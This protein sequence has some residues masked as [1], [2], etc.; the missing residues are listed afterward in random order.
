VNNQDGWDGE[1]LQRVIMEKAAVSAA[2]NNFLDD[3]PWSTICNIYNSPGLKSGGYYK[4][5]HL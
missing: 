4:S 3:R 5:F 2:V 1:M